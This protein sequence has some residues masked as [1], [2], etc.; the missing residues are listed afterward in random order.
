M[1]VGSSISITPESFEAN[2]LE[3]EVK[4][5]AASFVEKV[6]DIFENSIEIYKNHLKLEINV[7]SLDDY[8]RIIHLLNRM[9]YAREDNMRLS[10]IEE[11]KVVL[12]E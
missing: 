8:R 7:L 11:I 10:L 5:L 4:D 6:F 1:I 2:N 12:K 9:E 3:R